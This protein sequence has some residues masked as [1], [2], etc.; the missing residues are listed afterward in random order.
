[1]AQP[2]RFVIGDEL[3]GLVV[4]MLDTDG[5]PKVLTGWTAFLVVVTEQAKRAEI[6]GTADDLSLGRFLFPGVGAVITNEEAGARSEVQ[7]KAQVRWVDTDD[8][9]TLSYQFPLTLEKAL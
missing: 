3:R 6:N 8:K 9:P 2:N 5:T 1:M 4:T 7:V